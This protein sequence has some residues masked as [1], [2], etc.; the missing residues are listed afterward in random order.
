MAFFWHKSSREDLQ[1]MQPIHEASLFASPGFFNKGV[2]IIEKSQRKALRITSLDQLPPRKMFITCGGNYLQRISEGEVLLGDQKIIFQSNCDPNLLGKPLP[3]TSLSP[4]SESEQRCLHG[5]K[6]SQTMDSKNLARRE[7]NI[8]KEI[9]TQAPQNAVTRSFGLDPVPCQRI[10]TM[11]CERILDQESHIFHRVQYIS[12]PDLS[13]IGSIIL[14]NYKLIFISHDCYTFNQ[15]IVPYGYIFQINKIGNSYYAN[16]LLNSEYGIEIIS[17]DF[18]PTL[19]FRMNLEAQARNRLF[20]L[21]SSYCFPKSVLDTDSIFAWQKLLSA[22]PILPSLTQSAES[23]SSA[24][25][26]PNNSPFSNSKSKSKFPP[27][28]DKTKCLPLGGDQYDAFEQYQ[29]MNIPNSKWRITEYNKSQTFSPT[30]PKFIVV[31]QKI[32]DVQLEVISSFRS[33]G[34]IPALSYLHKHNSASITRSAQPLIGVKRSKCTEDEIMIEAISDSQNNP[35]DYN[36]NNN[37]EIESNNIGSDSSLSVSS[38]NSSSSAATSPAAE[39]KVLIIADARPVANA[40]INTAMGAGFELGG[41]Y[42]NICKLTFLGLGNIHVEREAYMRLRDLCT[43]L[44]TAGSAFQQPNETET[45]MIARWS[46]KSEY[47]NWIDLTCLTLTCS[48]SI[49]KNISLGHSVFVHCSDG[50]DRTPKLTS[51]AMLMLDSYYRT[52]AGFQNLIEQEWLRFGHKFFDRYCTPMNSGEAGVTF[53]HFIDCVWQLKQRYPLEFEWNSL[54]LMT[55]IEQLFER[56]FFTLLGNTD[57]ERGLYLKKDSE[58]SLWAYFN[59][60][61]TQFIDH[62]WKGAK[63]KNKDKKEETETETETKQEETEGKEEKELLLLMEVERD[64]LKFWGD[65]Y[66]KWSP[67]R[68][69]PTDDTKARLKRVNSV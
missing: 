5:T 50:W 63:N 27:E 11:R 1:H 29:R 26:S 43:N 69:K 52:I 60:N 6:R 7:I 49:A 4:L 62:E 16:T 2:L 64:E 65:Y 20:D 54:F 37:N 46:T 33:Q 12:S 30:Y 41:A 53:V 59:T 8:F 10:C 38:V 14:T 48:S 22:P 40:V 36:N 24:I 44:I 39:R 42:A 34:R 21:L 58:F 23:I 19:R 13:I 67:S 3:S 61:L 55:M 45:E 25:S 47:T 28:I 15:C 18:R 51:L 32:S 35:S 31:P 17:R 9:T 57:L 56:Q 66:L 68:R